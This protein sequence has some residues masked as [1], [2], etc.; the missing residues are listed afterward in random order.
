MVVDGKKYI[1]EDEFDK[2]VAKTVEDYFTT[3]KGLK[4]ADPSMTALTSMLLMTEFAVLASMLFSE[5]E[6]EEKKNGRD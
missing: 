2:G 1:S 5:D 4:G 3:T 6:K